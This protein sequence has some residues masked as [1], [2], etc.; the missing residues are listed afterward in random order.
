MAI[1]IN[2]NNIKNKDNG[3]KRFFLRNENSVLNK[4]NGIIKIIIV[5][6]EKT[7]QTIQINVYLKGIL[8]KFSNEYAINHNE[9]IVNAKKEGSVDNEETP[10][11]LNSSLSATDLV[12][13]TL[14]AA[15]KSGDKYSK[16]ATRRKMMEIINKCN[17]NLESTQ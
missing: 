1:K 3:Y 13:K 2:M 4:I 11:V 7:R 6:L 9:N 5:D 17:I 15:E 10:L 12:S 14:L 16:T 8:L